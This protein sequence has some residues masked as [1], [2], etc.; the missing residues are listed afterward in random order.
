[1]LLEDAAARSPQNATSSQRSQ[2]PGK[3]GALLEDAAARSPQNAT[4]IPMLEAPRGTRGAS[5]RRGNPL[6][7]EDAISERSERPGEPG[8][9]LSHVRSCGE[10]LATRYG[11]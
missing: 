9:S 1:A 11:C 8:R 3:P 10:R 5:R 6:P 7:L 4:S 2:R